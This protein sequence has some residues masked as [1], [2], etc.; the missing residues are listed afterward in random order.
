MTASMPCMSSAIKAKAA[1]VLEELR[2]KE[3]QT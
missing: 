2:D 3:V 1:A